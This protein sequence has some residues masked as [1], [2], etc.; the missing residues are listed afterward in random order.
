MYI[1]SMPLVVGGENNREFLA[2]NQ[3][4]GAS[5][6]KGPTGGI[7]ALNIEFTEAMS[8]L[9]PECHPLGY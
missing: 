6:C 2:R 8:D 1:A 4:S 7:G 9:I 5:L 3:A